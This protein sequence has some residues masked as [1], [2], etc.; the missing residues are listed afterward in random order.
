MKKSYFSLLLSISLISGTVSFGAALVTQ[1]SFD[2]GTILIKNSG[3]VTNLT[4]GTAADGNG[5]VIQLGYFSA[6]TTGT[7]AGNFLGVWTPLTG[8]GS[9]N[10][11]GNIA[12]SSPA[13]TFNK[14]SIGD[15]GG[16]DGEF[17]ITVV[18]N[19]TVLGTFNNLPSSTSIP[20]A[21]R[22]YNGTTIA[23]STFYNTV[24][25]DLWLWKF[26]AAAA[27]L[28]PTINMSLGASATGPGLKWESVNVFAQPAATSGTTSIPNVVAPEPT[29]AALLMVGLVSLAAR[30]RRAAKV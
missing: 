11:G 25:N 29:S 2:S 7:V 9:A 27:P 15:N 19:S 16:A 24:S 4:G 5:A 30:R 28:P 10:N 6:A 17:G 21:I 23:G 13:E 14:T 26:P 22:F 20:L 18:F 12:G 1:V 8:E 3:G